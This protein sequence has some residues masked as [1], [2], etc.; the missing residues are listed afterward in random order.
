LK[1]EEIKDDKGDYLMINL[2]RTKI[3]TVGKNAVGEFLRV[4]F[5]IKEYKKKKIKKLFI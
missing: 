2:D 3:K 1:I 5:M 4:I